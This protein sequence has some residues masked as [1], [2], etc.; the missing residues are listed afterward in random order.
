MRA[1]MPSASTM[2]K[3]VPSTAKCAGK[4]CEKVLNLG[5]GNLC[6]QCTVRLR[7][8]S[9]LVDAGSAS[10]QD[11]KPVGPISVGSV[12]SKSAPGVYDEPS[13]LLV[14]EKHVS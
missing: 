13:S 9:S 12:S 11:E 10:H 3:T 1:N 4:H 6:Q 5:K 8:R 7:R 2:P 14:S